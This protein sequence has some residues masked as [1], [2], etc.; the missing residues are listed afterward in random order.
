MNI[1][2]MSFDKDG[3]VNTKT[4]LLIIYKSYIVSNI[5][6]DQHWQKVSRKII[7]VYKI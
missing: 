6:L 1:C 3:V 2:P 4:A 5:I 7:I